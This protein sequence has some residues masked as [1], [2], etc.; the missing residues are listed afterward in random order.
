MS[1]FAV[2]ETGEPAQTIIR[3]IRGSLSKAGLVGL[4]S[5]AVAA[6]NPVPNDDLQIKQC[7]DVVAFWSA[8][9]TDLRHGVSRGDAVLTVDVRMTIKSA[10]G[11]QPGSGSCVYLLTENGVAEA[12]PAKIV[13]GKTVLTSVKDI[14]DALAMDRNFDLPAHSH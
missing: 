8:P 14:S 13:V 4:F 5:V 3:T 11:E 1:K 6:C 12:R 7:R 10:L 9:H 2:S